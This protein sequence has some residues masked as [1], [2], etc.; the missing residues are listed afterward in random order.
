MA[1][2]RVWLKANFI[3]LL[4]R[5]GLSKF[6]VLVLSADKSQEAT[7]RHLLGLG[8]IGALG[9]VAVLVTFAMVMALHI[10]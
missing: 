3:S 5:L 10:R 9:V 2:M 4:A 7:D 8:I 6:V 1:A